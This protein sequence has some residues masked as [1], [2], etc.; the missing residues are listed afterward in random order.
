MRKIH[1]NTIS[2]YRFD[3]LNLFILIDLTLSRAHNLSNIDDG[4]NVQ[5]MTC[6]AQLCNAAVNRLV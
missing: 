2:A 5:Y 4:R 6:I 1:N 3:C